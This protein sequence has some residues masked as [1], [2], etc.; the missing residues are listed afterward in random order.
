MSYRTITV[1]QRN[2]DDGLTGLCSRCPIALAMTAQG[3]NGVAVGRF[4]V[5]F[6]KHQ[7]GWVYRGLPAEA[8]AFVD[9]F[10]RTREGEPFEFRI[11]A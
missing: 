11:D 1:T 7:V 6:Y 8:V 5:R 4:S 10:D 3:F 2:I 9:H